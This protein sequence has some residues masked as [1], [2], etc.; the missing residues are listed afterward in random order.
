MGASVVE[1]GEVGRD[2]LDR[3]YRPYS[4]AQVR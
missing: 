3:G 4:S 2:A 1:N